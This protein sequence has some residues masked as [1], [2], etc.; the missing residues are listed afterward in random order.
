MAIYKDEYDDA[1]AF[2]KENADEPSLFARVRIAHGEKYMIDY[3]ETHIRP[4]IEVI[5]DLRPRLSSILR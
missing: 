4:G 2:I 3:T 5:E 1:V